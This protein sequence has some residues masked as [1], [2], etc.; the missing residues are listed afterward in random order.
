MEGTVDG[1]GEGTEEGLGDDTGVLGTGEGLRK[2]VGK[3]FG[4][5]REE[6]AG[7]ETEKWPRDGIN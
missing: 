2:G 4:K 7:E 3:G 6:V 1:L 5:E